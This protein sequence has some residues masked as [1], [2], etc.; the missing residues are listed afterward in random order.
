MGS[1]YVTRPSLNA[2]MHTEEERQWRAREMFEAIEDGLKIRVGG[3]Y[4]LDDAAQAHRDLESRRTQ[5][6]LLLSF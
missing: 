1:L 3:T 2:Y 4:S 5:G 6:K